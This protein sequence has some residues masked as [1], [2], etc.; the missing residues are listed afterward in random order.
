VTVSGSMKL[1]G[2][3]YTGLVNDQM[4]LADFEDV[5]KQGIA[6]EAGSGVNAND[7]DLILSE[8]SVIVDFIVRVPTGA[9]KDVVASTLASSPLASAVQSLLLQSAVAEAA[10]TGDIS[11]IV[12]GIEGAAVTT[13]SSTSATSSTTDSLT[14]GAAM[15]QETILAHDADPPEDEMAIVVIAALVGTGLV[16]G[17]SVAAFAALCRL[18]FPKR[19]RSRTPGMREATT[20]PSDLEVGG[21]SCSRQRWEVHSDPMPPA[22]PASLVCSLPDDVPPLAPPVSRACPLKNDVPSGR[23]AEV[24]AAPHDVPV[25]VQPELADGFSDRSDLAAVVLLDRPADAPVVY[26]GPPAVPRARRTP[27]SRVAARA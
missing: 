6:Q 15:G 12:T 7:V 22:P 20:V 25:A 8:G 18:G 1:Y 16:V 26:P 24:P 13:H 23:P 5:V 14:T 27:F 3:D 19:S 21:S 11:V 10:S 9:G 17:L 4:L 2:I